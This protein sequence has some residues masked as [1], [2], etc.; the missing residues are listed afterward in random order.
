M[1][2]DL[3]SLI[4]PHLESLTQLRR[5]I[6]SHPEIAFEEHHTS[7]RIVEELE[8]IP[9]LQIRKGMARG[10]GVIA[11]LGAD[12]AGP[13]IALR[14]DMDALP[15]QE[16]TGL[17]YASK[18]DGR[19]HACGHDGH[20]ACLIGAARVL[21]EISD[22]LAGPVRFIFQPAEEGGG[23]GRYM[24]EEGALDNPKAVAAFALHGWPYLPVGMVGGYRGG[25]SMASTDTISVELVGRGCHAAAPHNGADPIVAASHI[26]TALQT[27]RSR[28]ISPT[29][30]SVVSI[31]R[32][33][34]G[35]ANNIIAERLTFGG[36]IRTLSADV[37]EQV[38]QEVRSVIE[39]TAD[40]L[41]VKANV[42]IKEGYPV[43]V[44]DPELAQHALSVAREELGENVV[45]EISP[46]MGGED[47]AF[48]SQK[49]PVTLW[50]LGV[51][52]PDATEI[53][54]LHSPRYDFADAAIALGVRMHCALVIATQ[55]KMA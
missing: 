33:S 49:V 20:V 44:N 9:G 23:G 31:T 30:P 45:G 25:P 5:D 18:I 35:T 34:G 28:R 21:S 10:T 1:K 55:K 43:L 37:R 26:I 38:I 46:S 13:C 42:S 32:I 52:N 3:P 15:M 24:V 36:T 14:A 51:K 7:A 16:E 50:R 8:R 41:G 19:A 12:K 6:H 39:K 29:E 47:F 2:I 53:T 17:P 40:A 4:A 54:P 27:V 48:Y 22:Q 11:T